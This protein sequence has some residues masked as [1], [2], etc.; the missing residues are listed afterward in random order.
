MNRKE[1]CGRLRRTDLYSFLSVFVIT[2]FMADYLRPV[3]PV[4]D[5]LPSEYPGIVRL[6]GTAA[7][8][9]VLMGGSGKDRRYPFFCSG[10]LIAAGAGLIIFLLTGNSVILDL[11][12]LFVITARVSP[13]SVL[14]SVAAF[15]ACMTGATAICGIK[16]FFRDYT[17]YGIDARGFRSLAG[18]VIV[19]VLFILSFVS[20]IILAVPK[21]R[22]KELLV[23]GAL[24]CAL[25]AGMTLICLKVQNLSEPVASGVYELYSSDTDIS[26]GAHMTGFED[27]DIAF[28]R[29]A[30]TSFSI[31]PAG[32]QYRITFDSSGVTRTLCVLDGKLYA[33]NYDQALN[34][35]LWNI[36]EV[37]GTPYFRIINEKTGF[38]L[39]ADGDSMIRIGSECAGYYEKLS[40]RNISA[41][42]ISAAQ[43]RYPS[44]AAYTG[45]PV[46][47]DDVEIE[48]DGVLLK[49]GEDY[50]LRFEDN[51]LAGKAWILAEGRGSYEGTLAAPFEI[52]YDDV[53]LGNDFYRNVVDYV[54]RMYRMAYLRFPSVD[55]LRGWTQE[56]IGNNRTPDSVV[57]EVFTSGG[58]DVSNGQFMEALY[59]LMLLRNGSPEELS[60]WIAELEKGTS[61][62]IIIDNI[63]NS[64]DYQNIWHSF[65]ISFR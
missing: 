28:E 31:T 63:V 7:A 15:T 55:E 37:P 51:I 8:A 25:S 43:I 64:P 33:G 47:P 38:E 49:E 36:E 11:S 45:S 34:A 3:T 44:R 21:R 2:A 42:D 59:R 60:V 5:S 23:W 24:A 35:G 54:V 17:F 22:L 52:V 40:S 1:L 29:G 19:I 27:F 13:L 14:C 18:F 32:D 26:L 56:L 6:F 4:L 61:R 58:F 46:T 57:W 62:Y 53:L 9:A 20:V 48:M 50:T 10:A 39:A 12:I 65:Y 41:N 16:G 30:P